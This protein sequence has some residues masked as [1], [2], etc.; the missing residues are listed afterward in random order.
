[1]AKLILML[2]IGVALLP[3][4]IFKLGRMIWLNGPE[5]YRRFFHP[6]Q[7]GLKSIARQ[8]NPIAEIRWWQYAA[9]RLGTFIIAY[10]GIISVTVITF[11][12]AGIPVT[13]GITI[14]LIPVAVLLAVRISG[15]LVKK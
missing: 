3:I 6:R 12:L 5:I 2:A 9:R 14:G 8:L 13:I 1:M 10:L 4:I 7:K 11:A 15:A